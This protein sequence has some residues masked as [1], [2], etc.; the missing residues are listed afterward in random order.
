M[1]IFFSNNKYIMDYAKNVLTTTILI[2]VVIAVIVV[3]Y[4]IFQKPSSGPESIPVPVTQTKPVPT[5]YQ[6]IWGAY[7]GDTVSSFTNFENKVGKKA[8]IIAMFA[9]FSTQFPLEFAKQADATGHILLIFWEPSNVSL[10]S[11]ISGQ[12]DEYVK[13]FANQ[14]NIYG[15]PIIL[16]PMPEMNG[17]WD[18]W[19]GTSGN[20]SFAKIIEAWRHMHNLFLI[21]PNV[22]WG[23]T[24]N[25]VS[26]P[27]TPQNA[28]VNYYPGDTYVDYVGVDGFNFGNPWQSY[29][30][31]FS[32]ALQQLKIYDKPIYIFSMASAQGSQK[33]AWIVDALSQ[34]KSDSSIAGFVW[35]NQNKE[36]NWLVDSDAASLQAFQDGIK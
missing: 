27:D 33:A 30:D 8:D 7:S 6:K 12:Y 5:K 34:I 20:N 4:I 13:N 9:D 2:L 26:V 29:A 25:N 28:I 21:A 16:V 31:I 1:L 18:S 24:V 23:W 22:K 19:S 36:Q 11:I 15:K 32:S 35:F 14:A 3:L 10:D 17:N